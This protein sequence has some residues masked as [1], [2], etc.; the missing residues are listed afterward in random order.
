[1]QYVEAPQYAPQAVKVVKSGPP[2][3]QQ[4]QY[5]Q[6]EEQQYFEDID[7]IEPEFVQQTSK[8]VRKSMKN[9]NVSP[10]ITKVPMQIK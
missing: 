4:Q 7:P 1:V 3:M 9:V 8:V 6:A 5:Y 10:R 2:P